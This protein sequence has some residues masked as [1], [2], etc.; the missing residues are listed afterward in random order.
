MLDETR[1]TMPNTSPELSPQECGSARKGHRQFLLFLVIG[2]FAALVNVASRIAFSHWMT[3]SIAIVAA[4]L[5][6]MI[7]AFVLNRAIVF[8]EASNALKH[9]LF[10]FTVINLLAVAQ[11]LLVSLVLADYAFP[12]I[13]LDWHRETV[14]HAIGV[15]VPVLSS[16]FG[17]KYLSFKSH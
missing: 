7:T 4:Y 5:C 12:Y 3:Y 1:R 15:A 14:A 17:H 10:W 13:H 6:G 8:R 2:G 16:F 9:Q 11:T